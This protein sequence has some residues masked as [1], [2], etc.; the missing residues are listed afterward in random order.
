MHRVGTHSAED[1]CSIKHQSQN[2]GVGDP[3]TRDVEKGDV[4]GD[5]SPAAVAETQN[6]SSPSGEKGIFNPALAPESDAVTLTGLDDK[7]DFPEGGLKGW[8]VVVGSFCGSFSVFGIINSTAVLLQYFQE[9]QLKNYSPSQIGWI[10]GVS[11]FLTF[12]CGAPI[13][14]IFDAYGPRA[15][16]FCGS[17]L[18]VASM[19]LLGLCTQYWHFFMVYSVLNGIG[20]CLINTPCIASIGHFFLRKRGNATGIAMT[21]GSI[22][23][24]IFPLM[25]QRL[26]PMVGFAWATRILGFIILSLLIVANLLVRSRLPRKSIG[27]WKKVSPDLTVFKDLP[28][29]FVTLGIFLMEWGIFVPLTYITSY[30]VAHGHSSAFGFQ[31]LAILNAGSF[32]G[33]FFAGLVADLIGRMNTLI[34]SIA[35]CVVTC[36]ALWLPAGD[37]TIMIVVFAVIF[38]FTSGSNLSLSPVCVGQMCKTEN[39]GRYFATCWMF[40]AFGTLTSLPIAGQILTACGGNYN[41][42]IIFAGLSYAA[43][44][45][46]LAAARVLAVG[47]KFKTIY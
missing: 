39:Y 4:V 17:I 47:W 5:Q 26:F 44:G 34:L 2:D 11:L 28:F 24:I 3:K 14:P 7:D 25:L 45:I 42:V 35:M 13:G 21:S 6:S 19:F 16:I 30:A 33:R 29:T 20:G 43:A 10:F 15:L 8:S 32:F 40:V 22:G 38:G 12:F 27:S 36:F 1:S 9:H 31:I 37:S 18:L 41:G 23:G 46:S